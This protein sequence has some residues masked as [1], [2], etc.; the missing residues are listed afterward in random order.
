MKANNYIGGFMMK[1]HH[2]AVKK[3]IKLFLLLLIPIILLG[4][5]TSHDQ[6]IKADSKEVVVKPYKTPNKPPKKFLGIWMTD[7]YGLQPPADTYTTVGSEVVLRTSAGRSI[8]TV[9]GGLW[10]G[11]H[12]RWYKSTDGQKW[13]QIKEKDGGYKKNFSVTPSEIGTVWYQLDTQYYMIL[14]PIFKTHIYSEVA[15]VH[16]VEESVNALELNVTVDDK[17]LYSTSEISNTTY[18]H[19][20]PDPITATGNITWS[21]DKPEL[22]TI[23]E[24]GLI[25][26]NSKGLKGTVKVIATF[27]NND[28]SQIQGHD[29]VEVGG[30]LDDQT[31]NS[32]ET[33][34][35]TPKGDVG[36]GDDDNGSSGSL[37]VTW[38]KF[39]SLESSTGTQVASGKNLSYTTPPTTMSEDGS[40]Y[41][42]EIIFKAGLVSKSIITNKARLNVIPAPEPDIELTN[43][44]VNNTYHADG[45]TDNLLN[46]VTNHD[47]VTYHD[48]LTNKSDEGSLKNGYY[49]IPMRGGTKVNSVKIDGDILDESKYTL[50]D[51]SEDDS[52]DLVID[53]GTLD[54]N[55]SINIDVDTTVQN[56]SSEDSFTFIPYVYGSDVDGKIYRQEG[57]QE[58]INYISNQI[59]PVIQDID[60]G[61]ITPFSANVLK[62]RP[63]A[64]NTPNNIIDITDTRR[65]KVPM[66]VYVSQENDFL[67]ESESAT[68]PARLRYYDNGDYTDIRNQKTLLT[69]S[70]HG[71][72][73]SSISWDK[74]NGLLLYIDAGQK[75]TGR[76]ST[77]L[78]WYFE[79]SV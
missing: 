76:Y 4:V 25:T 77:T 5:T 61:T 20:T 6:N 2:K 36:D 7:G 30:G 26:A 35:F 52:D 23:D 66:K 49:V 75:L 38:K 50:V 34:T 55:E 3:I 39:A 60:F 46:D 16:T 62:Y 31:V 56:I 9:L 28:G 73:L 64:V 10:D 33:A 65:D 17:F 32:G 27:T 22:A 29:T 47:N 70:E 67:H 51:D 42:A 21:V 69:E 57:T 43:K 58:K 79:N 72:D 71:S 37:T 13:T 53:I 59:T 78:S 18:A 11:V 44:I 63:Q 14:T 74:N 15:A 45:D 54:T 41:Q 40:Y 48:Q 68:L 8:W 19:A 24:D 1:K 12:Y